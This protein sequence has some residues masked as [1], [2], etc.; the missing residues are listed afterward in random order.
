MHPAH[1]R[2]CIPAYRL[3][4]AYIHVQHVNQKAGI[5]TNNE[6]V[7]LFLS[8]GVHFWPHL[9]FFST[10]LKCA[11]FILDTWVEM[12]RPGSTGQRRTMGDATARPT[13]R[14]SKC[15]PGSSLFT[16]CSC[17]TEPASHRQVHGITSRL[18]LYSV[19]IV[20]LYNKQLSTILIYFGMLDVSVV[21]IFY[22]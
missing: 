1:I 6:S 10:L 15:W 21:F 8:Q 16:A 20:V 14:T 4:H 3:T 18:P 22:I 19:L 9:E 7:A 5:T 13:W 12:S 2:V 17:C 11:A